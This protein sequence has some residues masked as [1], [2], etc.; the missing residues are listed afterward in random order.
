DHLRQQL[1]LAPGQPVSLWSFPNPPN[2]EQPSPLPLL[3]KLAIHGS[4]TGKLTLQEIY[5]ELSHRFAWFQEHPNGPW[6]N[7]IRHNLSLNKVF[8]RIPRPV[9]ERGKGCYWALDLSGGEG[10]KRP[11]KR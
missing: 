8:K 1:N 4:Q 2:G 5:A 7:S 6:K 3:I 10:Y 11:R 9:T